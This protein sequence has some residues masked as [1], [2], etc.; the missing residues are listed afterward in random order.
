MP[1]AA[2]TPAAVAIFL[3]ILLNISSS[4]YRYMQYVVL[5]FASLFGRLLG[6][7]FNNLIHNLVSRLLC[8][9]LFHL[10]LLQLYDLF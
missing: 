7:R 9:A 10:L 4:F 5:L 1:A 3:N 6:N 8:K 2:R